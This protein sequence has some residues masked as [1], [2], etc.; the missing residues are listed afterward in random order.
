M[1]QVLRLTLQTSSSQGTY[2]LG[3]KVEEGVEKDGEGCRIVE[4]PSFHSALTPSRAWAGV[5]LLPRCLAPSPGIILSGAALFSL[6]SIWRLSGNPGHQI[7][8]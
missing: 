8:A 2:V 5:P 4:N 3:S 7:H 6:Q 1:T